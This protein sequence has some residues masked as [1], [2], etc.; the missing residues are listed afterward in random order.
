VMRKIEPYDIFFLET[1][2]PSDDLEG[3]PRLVQATSI[4]VAANFLRDL[5]QAS[6]GR[7]YESYWHAGHLWAL[8]ID[9]AAPRKFL[10]H[11]PVPPSEYHERGE[12][13]LNWR[14][15]TSWPCRLRQLTP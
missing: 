5:A 6:V 11:R 9:A 2:L 10:A 12:S 7:S 13:C 14:V 15:A 8:P 4:R 1:H 3:Y